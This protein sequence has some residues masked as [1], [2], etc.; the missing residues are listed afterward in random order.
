MQGCCSPGTVK[1][2]HL[3]PY[4]CCRELCLKTSREQYAGIIT[5]RPFVSNM[6]A[7]EQPRDRHLGPRYLSSQQ[8]RG[9]GSMDDMTEA[10]TELQVCPALSG[11]LQS[12]V[13]FHFLVQH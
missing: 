10:P 1:A 2:A 8:L 6:A 13:G 7:E 12:K 3:S 4:K 11:Q 5:E 9:T